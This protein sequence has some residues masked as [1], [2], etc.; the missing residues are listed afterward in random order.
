MKGKKILWNSFFLLLKN[1]LVGYEA[2]TP[3][4]ILPFLKL[5]CAYSTIGA[6]EY[7]SIILFNEDLNFAERVAKREYLKT[8]F[9][10]FFSS[11][12]CQV[13]YKGSFKTERTLFGVFSFHQA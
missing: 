3:E 13:T 2:K 10:I 12:I 1:S 5:I 7:L 8:Q 6:V 4:K 9:T 11:Q